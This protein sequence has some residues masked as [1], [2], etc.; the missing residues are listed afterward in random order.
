MSVSGRPRLLKVL[1]KAWEA[2]PLAPPQL[3]FSRDIVSSACD[4]T[5]GSSKGRGEM[6]TSDVWETRST[7]R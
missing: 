1:N 4:G 7:T 6:H 5:Q 2:L 3:S